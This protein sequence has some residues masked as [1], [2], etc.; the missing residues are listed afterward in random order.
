MQNRKAW[1]GILA[2]VVVSLAA[3]PV[4][5]DPMS[6][7][8]AGWTALTSGDNATAITLF[9]KAIGSGQLS[10]AYLE[11]AYVK[12]GEAF[13]AAGNQTSALG[14]AQSALALDPND[15]QA[16]E[17]RV[18]AQLGSVAQA[19]AHNKRGV[20]FTEQGNWA[21]ALPQFQ[22]A[23]QLDPA[24]P[25][26]A[27][28]VRS[29]QARAHNDRGNALEKQRDWA[30]ALAEYQQAQQF[31]PAEPVYAQNARGAQAALNQAQAEAHNERG[32]A[33]ANQSDW[34]DAL[35]EYEQAHQLNPDATHISANVHEAR[36]SVFDARGD[37][38][39]ALAEAQLAH[40]IWPEWAPYLL[41]VQRLQNALNQAQ[42]PQAQAAQSHTSTA[43]KM[44]IAQ[45]AVNI[46]GGIVA[47]AKG[48]SYQGQYVDPS[49]C[50]GQ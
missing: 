47:L 46:F 1:S 15:D 37:H 17:V 36:A 35:S 24:V 14:D 40:Q 43:C 38:V 42:A 20:A 2:S 30:G 33:F 22:L 23:Q 12:R 7:A 45:A 26:Y 21:A 8:A 31:D 3:E 11:K 16:L 50:Q 34:P 29:A 39:N 6:D 13:F 44:E 4:L 27:Q 49:Q 19:R 32:V 28:N 25:G 18:K 9:T 48:G 5:A 41:A 10:K